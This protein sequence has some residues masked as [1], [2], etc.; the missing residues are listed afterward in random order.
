MGESGVTR[1]EWWLVVV[2]GAAVIAA[3]CA[4]PR[5]RE[6]RSLSAACSLGA[7][8][9]PGLCDSTPIVSLSSTT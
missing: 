8:A 2:L 4:D 5:L 3:A 9:N 6:R 7:R 1:V